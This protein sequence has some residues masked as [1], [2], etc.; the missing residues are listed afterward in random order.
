MRQ[1]GRR[2]R[3]LPIGDLFNAHSNY[4]I[5]FDLKTE[6]LAVPSRVVAEIDAEIR[7]TLDK[8]GN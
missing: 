1:T 2:V 6:M 3:F 8:I 4:P 5:W 7:A